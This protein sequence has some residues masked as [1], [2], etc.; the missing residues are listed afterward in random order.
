[1]EL[2]GGTHLAWHEREKAPTLEFAILKGKRL[3]G[4][5]FTATRA[6]WAERG[7]QQPAGW[8]RLERGGR[9]GWAG[10][11][12]KIQIKFEFKFQGFCN[13]AR[14]GKILQGDLEGIWTWDF[15]P[16]FF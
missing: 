7:G 11:R 8:S 14:H 9:A 15:F 5:C 13:L 1:M 2:M 16:K 10:S 3:S 12:G 4:E 6:E